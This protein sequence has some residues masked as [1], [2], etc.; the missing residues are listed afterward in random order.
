MK[1]PE[2][3]DPSLVSTS[4]TGSGGEPS[5]GL[6]LAGI[7]AKLNGATGPQYWRS[8]EEVAGTKEF[9]NWLYREFPAGAS[10]WSDE[11]SRRS[12][13]KLAGASLA[14]AGLSACA[15]QPTE[16][17]VPYVRQPEEIVLGEPLFYASSF[18]M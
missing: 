1:T 9:Q 2:H 6:D 11:V 8:L 17:I 3:P 13:L 12:F 7:R 10:E 14:L 5:S 16:K 18:V 4:D 15:Q